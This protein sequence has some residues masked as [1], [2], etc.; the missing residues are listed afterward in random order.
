MKAIRIHQHGGLEELRIDD[1]PF[2][3]VKPKEVLVEV[4]STSL[5]H[6]DLW[7]RKGIPGVKLPLPLILGSDASGVVQEVGSLVRTFKSGDRVVVVPGAGCGHCGECA[8]G[9]ENYCLKYSIGGEHG[10]GVQSE[11]IALDEGRF[12]HLP[13]NVSFD[14]GAAIPL[15]YQ[16]AWEMVVNKAAVRAGQ[17]VLVWGA[18]SGVGSAAAQIAKAF[19]AR[20]VTTA[21]SAEKAAKARDLLGADFVV[22]YHTQDVLKEVRTI[23]NGRGVDVV[24]DHVGAAT[25]KT[26]LRALAKG[27]KLVFCGATTG[28]DVSFDLRHVFFKQQSIIGSTMGTRGDLIKVLEL[29]R[30]RK[31]GGV[32]D[33]VF[34]FTQIRE[35]HEFL[36]SGK[37]F[38]KVIV[39][40]AH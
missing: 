10:D 16:T 36:E 24:V 39:R 13:E 28:A 2:P 8:S 29:I 4:K 22:D 18:S 31:L 27:G 6:L 5:N 9:R 19:E 33:R 12:L 21:G 20:V 15:V 14:E 35:A 25:W 11:F 26:S 34:E 37:Q 30:Q 7:V 32:V 1:V 38:G 17:T 23:T 3:A 40:F